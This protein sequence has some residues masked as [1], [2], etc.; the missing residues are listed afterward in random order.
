[1][2]EPMR[3]R[4]SAQSLGLDLRHQSRGCLLRDAQ[5]GIMAA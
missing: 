5:R 3:T 4:R 2:L 1:M